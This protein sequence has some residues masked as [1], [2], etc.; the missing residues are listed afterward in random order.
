MAADSLSIRR[1]NSQNKLI[2]KMVIL[3][4]FYS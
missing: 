3:A 2:A 1:H 4:S